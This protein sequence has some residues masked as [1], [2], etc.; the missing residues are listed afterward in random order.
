MLGRCQNPNN[1]GYHNYGGRGIHVVETWKEFPAF[2]AWSLANGY[3]IG[4][5]LDR[6]N[7]D[8]PYDPTNCRW[9]PRK[10]NLRNRRNCVYVTFEDQTKT[11]SEW[12]EDERCVVTTDL[13]NDRLSKEWPMLEAMSSAPWARAY[14]P[15][16]SRPRVIKDHCVHGHALVEGNVSTTERGYIRC[17]T[18]CRTAVAKSKAK[19]RVLAASASPSND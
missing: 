14:K 12:A 11:I 8:G 19:A 16:R 15:R 6:T 4:L 5:D 10:V 18:C 3:A 7:N 1:P 9:V 2:A 17:K 13:L